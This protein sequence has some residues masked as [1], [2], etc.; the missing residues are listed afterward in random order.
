VATVIPNEA[1]LVPITGGET[2]DM[3]VSLK[4]LPVIVG[5]LTEAIGSA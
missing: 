3:V 5:V 2:A 1:G 4:Y